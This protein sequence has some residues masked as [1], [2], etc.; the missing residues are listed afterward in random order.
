MYFA[1]LSL[2]LTQ[3]LEGLIRIYNNEKK[4]PVWERENGKC[5]KNLI[6]RYAMQATT[7]RKKGIID[8]LQGAHTA[9][10]AVRSLYSI[11]NTTIWRE[12]RDQHFCN[13]IIFLSRKKKGRKNGG[14]E[15]KGIQMLCCS[16]LSR[17]SLVKNIIG[18][19]KFTLFSLWT[20]LSIFTHDLL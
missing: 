4:M 12:L 9:D 13:K 16:F 3:S 10:A 18:W 11:Q 5:G 7:W 1:F 17:K 14:G 20:L 6:L 19:E 8:F 15:K 2:S